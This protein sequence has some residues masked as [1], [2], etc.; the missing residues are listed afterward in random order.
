MTSITERTSAIA[1]GE[2]KDCLSEIYMNLRVRSDFTITQ[3]NRFTASVL[4]V[5]FQSFPAAKQLSEWLS[6]Q[7]TSVRQN[8]DVA[9][10]DVAVSSN[11]GPT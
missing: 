6:E 8:A 5:F 7:H 4:F 3:A 9:P 2:M 11:G 10:L 1:C